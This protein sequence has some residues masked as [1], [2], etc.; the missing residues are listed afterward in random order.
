MTI[1][2]FKIAVMAM[3]LAFTTSCSDDD[4]NDDM[5]PPAENTKGSMYIKFDHVWGPA[6]DDF[7]L[8]TDLTHPASGEELRFTKLRYYIS[9]IEL[10][11]ANGDTWKEEESYHIVDAENMSSGEVELELSDLPGGSYTGISYMIGVD[12]LRN[13]SGAQEGA[14]DPAE[15]MFWSWNTGYIF[16]KAEGESNMTSNGSFTYHLGGF[17]GPFKANQEKYHDFQGATL[18]ISPADNP[19]VHV[20]VNAARFWH[21]G[22]STEQ[23]PMMHMPGEMAQTLATNFGGGFQFDHIHN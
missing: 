7:A 8:N 13:V 1:K 10:Q 19:A 17:S 20:T 11:N 4:N 5:N 6:Q 2:F 18:E 3:L 9:N 12:S 14:L 22:L 16:I 21:G 23:V 15:N